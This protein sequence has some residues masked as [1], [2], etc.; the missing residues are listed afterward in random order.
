MT[1]I[2]EPPMHSTRDDGEENRKAIEKTSQCRQPHV[3]WIL[4][5]FVDIVRDYW[6]VEQRCFCGTMNEEVSCIAGRHQTLCK[7]EQEHLPR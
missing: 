3:E 5:N 7:L 1:S 2:E 4:I 6:S